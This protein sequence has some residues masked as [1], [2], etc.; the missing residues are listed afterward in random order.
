MSQRTLTSTACLLLMAPIVAPAQET[1]PTVLEE[2]MVTA[3]KRDESLQD[4][5][6]SIT[7]FSAEQL[8]EAQ[9]L[10]LV[11]LTQFSPGMN[12]RNQSFSIAGRW[13]PSIRFRGLNSGSGNPAFQVGAAFIDGIFVY[14][15]LSAMS[16]FDVERVEVI[17]GPQNAYFGR[18]TFSGAVNFISREPGDEWLVQLRGGVEEFDG[19]TLGIAVE[20][21]IIEDVLSMRFSAEDLTRGGQFDT[22]DE[23]ELVNTALGESK[24]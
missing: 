13:Q 21:P 22:S 2:I 3:R 18:N 10:D 9:I 14:G 17:K 15:S 4:I 1:E 6:V 5:P 7:A 16:T 24:P 11:D 19:Q 20:G 12:F 8:Q 23:A